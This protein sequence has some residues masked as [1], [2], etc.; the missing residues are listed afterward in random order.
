MASTMKIL[1][2]PPGT[3][4]TW[5]AVHEAVKAIDPEKYD[6][7]IQQPDS[8]EQIAAYHNVMVKNGRI[9]WVTFHPGY[10]YEDFM[11]GYRPF[12]EE[13][14]QLTYKVFD[15][16]FKNLCRR[17]RGDVDL[18]I[19]EKLAQQNGVFYGEIVDK[20]Q[21]GWVVKI[22]VNR[23]DMIAPEMLKYVDRYTI[24]RIIASGLPASIFS[25]P[26]NSLVDV[27]NYGISPDASDLP[28]PDPAKNETDNQRVGSNLRRVV[29]GRVGLSSSDLANASHYGAVMRRLIERK[30]AKPAASVALVI[31]EINRADLS[32][33]FGELL[34]LLELNKREG[35]EEEK[36]V[37]LPYSKEQFSVPANLSVIGTMN[38]VDRSLS[39]MDF[40]MRRRFEFDYIDADPTLCPS[41]YG[42]VD[43]QPILSG[44]NRGLDVLLGKDYRIGHS[45]LM[46]KTLDSLCSKYSWTEE[47][48]QLKAVAHVFRTRILPLLLEYF[49]DDWRKA[50]AVAGM[51]ES[52]GNS[53]KLFATTAPDDYLINQLPD[54]YD[55]E[56]TRSYDLDLWWHPHKTTWDSLSFKA[57][58]LGLSARQ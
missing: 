16:P 38:T 30:E 33:V 39:A 29:G 42:G 11:E 43:I 20:D 17:A 55:L 32:R 6:Y 23:S 26:G 54:E 12:T 51:S 7:L 37:I 19:G 40:A 46:Q 15:G 24:K 31:D 44:I 36:R 21:G 28:E 56:E 13:G 45:F 52:N 53:Y 3:G 9:V 10:S 27:Q 57:F 4:K 34:T 48:G 8:L 1:Y 14:G 35:L 47:E 49:H 50:E 25:I 41:T 5:L 58:L 2:G 22:T 18:Q